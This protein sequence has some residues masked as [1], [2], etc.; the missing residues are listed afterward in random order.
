MF[1]YNN[2]VFLNVDLLAFKICKTDFAISV[3]ET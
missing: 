2:I 1:K 3:L